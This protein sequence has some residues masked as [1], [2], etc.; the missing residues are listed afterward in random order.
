MTRHLIAAGLFCALVAT[1]VLA[2]AH[3]EVPPPLKQLAA[4]VPPGEIRCN[5][6]MVQMQNGGRPACVSESSAQKLLQRGWTV[7]PP[8][9]DR[10]E[11]PDVR[12]EL[13]AKAMIT[14]NVNNTWTGLSS[15]GW[16]SY[17]WPQYSLTFPERVRVGEQF[18]VVLDYTFIIHADDYD[19]YGVAEIAGFPEE[20]E[21]V[22]CTASCME[23][24]QR[25]NSTFDI[26]TNAYVDLIDDVD[27]VHVSSFN[28]TGHFPVREFERGT[29]PPVF[30]NAHPQQ[31]TFTFVINEPDTEYPFGHIRIDWNWDGKGRI[32]FYAEP[33]NTVRLSDE[34]IVVE[35]DG[36]PRL[37]PENTMHELAAFLKEHHPD[38]AEAGLHLANFTD[39]FIDR[40]FELYPGLRTR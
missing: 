24:L 39:A 11:R 3:A 6:D 4:G 21:K 1:V 37:T 22:W 16:A 8:L 17:L 35:G 13:P 20:R 38:D 31:K 18:E 40:F 28:D 36:I 34:P 32:H 29:V 25:R 9:Q 19:R 14:G 33:D 12:A 30:N 15:L 23:N 26:E 27:Y 10:T 7:V 5:G 2:H